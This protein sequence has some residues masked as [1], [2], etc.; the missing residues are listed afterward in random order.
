MAQ[1]VNVVEELVA[2][3][4]D[5]GGS[6]A[7][8]DAGLAAMRGD[9]AFMDKYSRQIGA[10]GLEAMLK[11][12]KMKVLIVGMR[13][14]GVEVAKN[15][16]LAGVHTMGLYDPQPTEIRDLGSN[17]FLSQEDVG[18]PRASVCVP[19]VAEL[20]PTVRVKEV[21]LL[22]EEVVAGY[23]A[24]VFT[25]G[26]QAEA[27]RWN[28]FCR[29]QSPPI[30]FLSC[31][32]GGAVGSIF[33]DCGP[34]HS[35]KDR[36]GRNPLVKIVES[37]EAR[38]TDE[39]NPYYLVRYVTPEGQPPEPFPD[40][41]LVEFSDVAGMEYADI[42]VGGVALSLNNIHKVTTLRAYRAASDPVRTVRLCLPTKGA[43]GNPIYLSGLSAWDSGAVNSGYMT[44][45][46]EAREV[47]FDS[48]AQ[49]IES[50]GGVIM[51]GEFGGNGFSMF[52]MTFSMVEQQIHV[53]LQGVKAFEAAESGALPTANDEAHAAKVLEYA[54]V[55]NAEHTVVDE[56]NEEVCKKVALHAGVELQPLCAFLGG[57]VSQELVKISGKYTPIMQWLNYHAFEALPDS[58]PPAAELA[59]LGSRY[60]DQIAVFGRSFQETLGDLKLFMVG[61]GALGCEFVKNFAL[62]GVCCGPS[63]SLTITDND[64]IEV[65]NLN[66]QFLFR[67]DNGAPFAE[68][69]V[70]CLC[71]QLLVSA[72]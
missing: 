39:G 50:P 43:E 60:D 72:S 28:E 61:C 37:I 55:F 26:T 17:F 42:Q 34:T 65:S 63:G 29:C 13:G 16:T 45:K 53:A 15:T 11:L 22:S 70:L 56:V 62:T 10:Y 20:N 71:T 69:P 3:H 49:S 18:Q 12:T 57:I 21:A 30:Y 2:A 36:D 44:E 40:D 59:P 41:G 68:P 27:I 24:V 47:A 51:P 8:D 25:K 4:D 46:K 52:D 5:A 9:A 7:A 64:R 67:S 6:A 54:R 23:T 35:I 58:P 66:R 48:L 14:V 33:V 38:E 31:F 32:S 19:K 1:W